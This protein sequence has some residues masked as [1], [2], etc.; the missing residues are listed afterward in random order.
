M[1][2]TW[3]AFIVRCSV[4]LLVVI[5]RLEERMETMRRQMGASA[6]TA[7]MVTHEFRE[8]E[9]TINVCEGDICDHL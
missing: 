9:R 8:F 1:T 3:L 4:Q 5:S 2:L 6:Q 7:Q